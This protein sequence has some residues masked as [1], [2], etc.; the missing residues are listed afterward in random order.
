MIAVGQVIAKDA[1]VK[2]GEG[3]RPMTPV[4]GRRVQQRPSGVFPVIVLIFFILSLFT[5]TGRRMLPF[6]LLMLLSGRGGGGG[7]GGGFGGGGFS[8]GFGG[9]LSGGGGAGRS[10]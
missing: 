1:G 10:F 9:G 7:F 8:G 3:Y 2:I 4:G 6:V 5:R